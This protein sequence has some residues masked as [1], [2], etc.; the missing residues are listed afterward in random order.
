MTPTP[1]NTPVN[2]EADEATE[3]TDAAAKTSVS[4]DYWDYCPN[5]GS[6]LF[7]QGCKYRCSKC[8]YFMSCSDFD[9]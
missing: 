5:C 2:R 7:N 3:S 8:H 4:G 6:R 9:Q 1:S